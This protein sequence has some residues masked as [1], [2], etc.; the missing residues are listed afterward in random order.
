M[1]PSLIHE[2]IQNFN[3]E[4]QFNYSIHVSDDFGFIYFNN[5]K[6]GC[7]TTKAT[8]NLAC[9]AVA[10]RELVYTSKADIHQRSKNILRRPADVGYDRFVE[11]LDDKA[12]LK[13]AFMRDP[14]DRLASAF[15]NKLTWNSV[16]KRA[17]NLALG[18]PAEQPVAFADFVSMIA[19]NHT[20]RDIDEHW[21]LQKKQICYDL[22]PG[23]KLFTFENLEVELENLLH[24]LFKRDDL[25]VFDIRKHFVGN[26]SASR[27]RLA[28]IKPSESQMILSTYA[29]DV[30]LYNQIVKKLIVINSC[31]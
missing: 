29:Q 22:V 14:V 4:R 19:D 2:F 3:G 15:E 11:M 5:P 30:H 1:T 16:H 9:A 21:R 20:L 12:I 13:F 7:S 26:V 10:G 31:G 28:E 25:P 18:R 27:R 17:L 8:L 6:C 24:Q 23:Q